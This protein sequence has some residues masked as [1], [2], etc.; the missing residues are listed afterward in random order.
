MIEFL[1]SCDPPPIDLRDGWLCLNGPG[2]WPAE[3]FASRVRFLEKFFDLWPDYLRADLDS[4][5][6]SVAS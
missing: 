6:R 3:D 1:L 5:A 4:R 2:T